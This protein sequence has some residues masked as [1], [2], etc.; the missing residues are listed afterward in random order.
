MLAPWIVEELRTVNLKDARLNARLKEVLSQLA[1]RPTAS[2]PAACGGRAEME[3]AY[4]L[5]DNEKVTF[6][7]VLESHCQ[8]TRERIAAQEVVILAQD[9]TEVDLTRPEQQVRGA[10]PLDAGSRRGALLHLLH[11]FTLDGTPL[12]TVHAA[13]WV[14]DKTPRPEVTGTQRAAIPL[15][16]KESHRAASSAR[17]SAAASAHAVH[18]RGRQRSGHL[19]TA[20]GGKP[21]V[22]GR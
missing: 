1:A 20:G 18:L 19:R 22:A 5:F 21:G 4:R 12:G 15:E 8:A 13:P 14:R 7:N 11:A 10:G 2:I 9:T 16:E 6:E 3:A 17:R